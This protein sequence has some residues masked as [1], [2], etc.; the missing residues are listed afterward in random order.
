ME[1]NIINIDLYSH[2]GKPKLPKSKEYLLFVIKINGKYQLLKYAIHQVYKTSNGKLA[3]PYDANEYRNHE[4]PLTKIEAKKINFKHPPKFRIYKNDSDDW[5]N[6]TYPKPYYLIENHK[7]IPIYGNSIE[8][9][10]K[11]RLNGSLKD[12]FENEKTTA[13]NGYK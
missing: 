10:I 12:V 11:L 7:A 8:D 9:Y 3:I 2:Y 4:K 5:I 6:R 1:E 13:N